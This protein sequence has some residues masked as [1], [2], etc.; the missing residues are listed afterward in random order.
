[1]RNNGVP[2]A[3]LRCTLNTF[4][5]GP[6]I[7]RALLIKSSPLVRLIVVMSGAKLI[8]SEF[9]A[10]AMA[11]RRVQ[12]APGQLPPASA[13]LFTVIVAASADAAKSSAEMNPASDIRDRQRDVFIF[14]SVAETGR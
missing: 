8:V 4:A 6:L 7:V 1:M 5:P 9:D 14:R 11:C 10:V 2:G 13:A 3:P 12:V